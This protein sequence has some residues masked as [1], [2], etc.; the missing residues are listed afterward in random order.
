MSNPNRRQFIA[1]SLAL[2]ASHSLLARESSYS[3]QMPD[4]LLNHLSGKLNTLAATWDQ[5]RAKI[6]T[7]ADLETRNRFV[8][9]KFRQ[10]I[11]GLPERNPLNPLVAGTHTRDGYRVEN[12]MFQSRPDFWVTGNL[13]VPSSGSGPFPAVISPCGHYPLARM[14]PDYQFAYLNMVKAGFVVL[15]YDPIGQGERRQYWNPQTGHADINDSVFE[16]SMPGQALLLMGEDLTHYRIWDGMRAIDYL[17]T[18]PE[19]DPQRIACAG[20]S[21]GG[22]L[23]LF[24]SALDERVKCAVVN[25]GALAIAGRSRSGRRA[26]L[27][28]PTS[29]RT[30]FPPRSTESICAICM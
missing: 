10:M 5:D 14:Y 25:E 16:H 27:D 12:V 9:E 17:L 13:Y 15:A 30:C 28:H 20:H 26:A 29:S 8:R 4:M 1:A 23:T 22:T 11:H 24:I 3:E 18:R 6:R 19:V 2:P 7:A 21:G